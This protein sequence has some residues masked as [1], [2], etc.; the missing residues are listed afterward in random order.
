[1]KSTVTGVGSSAIR[2][3]DLEETPAVDGHVQ[4]L[5]GLLQVTGAEV[6]LGADDLHTGTQ[7]QARR[8][9]A[10]LGRLGAWLALDLIKQVLELGAIT[11][12]PRGRHVRQV[13]G[14]GGQV[15]V[16]RGQTCFGNP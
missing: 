4:R 9:F 14:D 13:V 7:L 11:F 12:E 10:V 5:V 1:M 15:G 6:L 8:Q 16:L 3:Q 2:L